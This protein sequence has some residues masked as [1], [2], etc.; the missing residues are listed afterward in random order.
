MAPKSKKSVCLFLISFA[1]MLSCFSVAHATPSLSL[2]FY[3]DNGYGMGNDINGLWTINTN[4]SEDVVYLE[5]YLD[6]ALQ[7]NDTSAPF[8]WQFDTNNYELGLRMIKVVAFNSMGETATAER[9]ANFVGFPLA[10]VVGII[11]V[12][13]VVMIVSLVVLLYRVRKQDQ[14]KN[15]QAN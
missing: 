10:F 6:D 12:I 9:E 3:K 14:R 11:A 13:V 5:F 2:S 15:T 7:L 1:L 4:V 8:S